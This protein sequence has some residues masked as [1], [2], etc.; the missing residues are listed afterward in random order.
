MSTSLYTGVSGLQAAQQ[1]RD[2]VGNNLANLNTTG[3]KTQ[4]VNFADLVY[5]TL[6]QPTQG[7]TGGVGGTDPTQVGLGTFLEGT[8]TNFLQ[9]SLQ[10][11]GRTYDLAV[12]GNGFFAVSNGAGTYYTRAGS[13]DVDAN[14]FLVDPSTGYKVQRFGT[15]GE[16]TATT[17]AFQTAASTD[18]KIPIG[19]GIPGTGTQNVTLQGNLSASLATNGTYST[20]IQIFDSQGTGHSL[21]LTFTKTATNT[22]GLTGALSDGGTVTVPANTSITFNADGSLAGPA[23]IALSIAYPA[24][25]GVTTPQAVTLKLGTVGKTDGLTQFGGNSSAAAINQDGAAAGSLT[26]V[27]VGQDGTING[28]FSNGKILAI[29][30]IALA[31]FANPGGLTR[32]GNN[33]YAATVNSGPPVVAGGLAGGRGLVQ[34]GTLEQSN[35]DVSTEFTNLIIAQRS[36]QVN[37][38]A[39]TTSSEVLQD[40]ANIIR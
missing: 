15:V 10:Q 2:V 30:Q 34:G 36:F 37:A 24:A 3:F 27:S 39:I 33:Y 21:S 29:A 22:F 14:G 1:M 32:Q 13:F 31:T 19:T 26:S 9:G 5:Q 8:S 6:S 28:A 7:V 25:I 20:A 23:T 12:E 16:G 11:T 17:P 40:L 38:K 18:I 35:V 4:A